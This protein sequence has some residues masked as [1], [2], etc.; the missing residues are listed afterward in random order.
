MRTDLLTSPKII[1]I[2]RSCGASRTTVVGA[3]FALWSL[4]DQHSTDGILI[5]YS[6]DFVDEYVAVRGFSAAA[7]SVGWLVETAA[8]VE[9]PRFDE[10]N[11]ASAKSRAMGAARASRFRNGSSVTTAL[12][13]EE[14]EKR[15]TTASARA[16]PRDTGDKSPGVVAVAVCSEVFEN[17]SKR[18]EWLPDGKPWIDRDTWEELG[19]TAGNAT[20]DDLQK[21]IRRA[22][23]SR[24]TLDNPAGFVIAELRKISERNRTAAN[25]VYTEENERTT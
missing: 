6:G 12:S 13:R 24:L 4:A 10:H 5:G 14:K 3:C 8:G 2:A 25:G 19:R 16:R 23:S 7:A 11:S 20:S 9:I 1:A 17:L 18:P 15:K 22:R 21:I